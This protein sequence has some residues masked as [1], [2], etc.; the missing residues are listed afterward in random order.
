MRWQFCYRF[1]KWGLTIPGAYLA[2]LTC[3]GTAAAANDQAKKFL[4]TQME[5][6]VAALAKPNLVYWF[7]GF[8][9][10]YLATFL[11]TQ[12]KSEAEALAAAGKQID[13]R[14]DAL[15]VWARQN[16][17]AVY[18][19]LWSFLIAINPQRDWSGYPQGE[20][21]LNEI[22]EAM[23]R[24]VPS[25]L[26]AESIGLVEAQTAFLNALSEYRDHSRDIHI[27]FGIDKAKLYSTHLYKSWRIHDD[28]FVSNLRKLALQPNLQ[29]IRAHVTSD[30]GRYDREELWPKV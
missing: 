22:Y 5:V 20:K 15:E 8:A 30:W 17:D 1:L 18:L 11:F 3:I 12:L 19:E 13:K 25:D 9:A 7:S 4:A 27:D 28:N 10:I 26:V 2:V 21:H 6:L 14:K 24:E 23:S 16:F 29:K